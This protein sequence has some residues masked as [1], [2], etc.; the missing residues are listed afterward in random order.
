MDFKAQLAIAQQE[1]IALREKLFQSLLSCRGKA[2]MDGLYAVISD[3]CSAGS[4]V[5]AIGEMLPKMVH[6]EDYNALR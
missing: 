5:Y 6:V 2:L 4:L 3:C 1:I